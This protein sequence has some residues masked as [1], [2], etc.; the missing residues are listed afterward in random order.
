MHYGKYYG[1]L[2]TMLSNFGES[3]L[4]IYAILDLKWLRFLSD[5][6]P[7]NPTI[8][9]SGYRLAFIEL[10]LDMP[11]RPRN[12]TDSERCVLSHGLVWLTS[13]V[14]LLTGEPYPLMAVKKERTKLSDSSVI[15]LLDQARDRNW[16]PVAN[17]KREYND[18]DCK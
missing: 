14:R 6:C 13:Q 4:F 15:L 10:I 18:T 1:T 7:Y 2:K 11:C 5:Y 3:N 17:I 16:K 9:D 8:T 12:Q